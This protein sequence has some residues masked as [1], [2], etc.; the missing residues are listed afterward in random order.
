MARKEG[1][2]M[3]TY[4]L[5][6]DIG[7]SSGRHMLSHMEDGKM[8]L[9]EVY[10]FENGM[11]IID[12]HRYWNTDR[13]FA[14]IKNGLKKAKELGKVPVSMGI[15]TWAVDYVLLDK[16]DVP[17]GRTYGY[18]DSRT[19]GMDEEVYKIIPETE[20]YARTGIQK[21]IF[22]TIYQL[23]AV[24]T[25][26]PEVLASAE[27]MLMLPDY[28]H[29]L[30]TGVK[31]QEY[32]NATSTQ[33]VNPHTNDWDYELIEKLG[34]P[35]KMFL[36]V[37]KPGT[38]VGDF[39]DEI[40]AEIGYKCK[41]VLPAT[42][43]TGSA[44]M[45]LPTQSDDTLYI[46]SGTWS[47]MGVENK[48]AVCTPEAQAR[49]FTNEGGYD[50]RFRFLKNIMGLWMIQQVRHELND[51]YS[52]AELCDMAEAEKEFPTRV[53]V[54]DV[55]FLAPDNM[56]EAVR[57]YARKTNQQVPETTGQMAAVI[58]QSLALS[59]AKTVK[60]IEELTGKHYEAINIVGGGSKAKYLNELT[61][62][63]TGRKVI[64]GPGE[65][66]AIGNLMAQMITDGV[67]RNLKDARACVT[68][69]FDITEEEAC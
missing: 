69:S 30:L 20:L 36:P 67:F 33:L 52:F 27:T 5:A 3:T 13:L 61:A 9:E 37:T 65:G 58:Y 29:F 62:R 1:T 8:V 23:M 42:H 47:L 25:Q 45:A 38:V 54:N 59:Y 26:E 57:E 17:C 2:H 53:D 40:A 64:A 44:I 14:E 46:S 60:E 21:Q 18:R 19:N 50:Y 24:K 6:V 32:T 15:D 49:N 56:Q 7:A 12:G 66:T 4:Y 35:T 63:A 16:N 10:R 41:V 43:D 51:G 11:D 22:N 34:Y 39:T 28:F 48:E 55:S 31:K 68:V